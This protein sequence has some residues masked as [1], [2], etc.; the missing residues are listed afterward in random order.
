MAGQIKRIFPTMFY[1][2][3]LESVNYPVQRYIGH[4]ADLK[5]RLIE[6][7]SGKCFH[8]SKFSPWKLKFYIAFEEL[9]GAQHFEKYLKSGSGHAFA[10]RH[11]WRDKKV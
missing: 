9:E 2:Y 11:F 7:N 4:T 10:K 1:T 6:H 5:Q 3:V 8:T